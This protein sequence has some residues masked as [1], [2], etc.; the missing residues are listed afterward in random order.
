MIKTCCVDALK[1]KQNVAKCVVDL[2]AVPRVVHGPT[3]RV[4]DL[5]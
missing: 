3:A 2:P 1:K 4:L 5:E